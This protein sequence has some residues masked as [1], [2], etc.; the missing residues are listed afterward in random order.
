MNPKIEKAINEQIN[1]EFYSSYLYLSMAAYFD[2]QNLSGFASWMK[3]QAHEEITH[4][5][6]FYNFVF[7]RG[8]DV[9]LTQIDKPSSDFKSGLDAAEQTLAHEQEVTS[10]INKLYELALAEK[11]YPTQSLLKWYIDEQVEEEENATKLIERIKIVGDKGP[12]IL[13]LDRELSMRKFKD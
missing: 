4:A 10:L 11:D 13:M 8:G 6:K 5:M 1:A 9:E 3:V 2:S 12:N 7:S